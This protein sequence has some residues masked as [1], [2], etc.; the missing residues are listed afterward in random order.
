MRKPRLTKFG[1]LIDKML[2]N[3]E[4]WEIYENSYENSLKYKPLHYVFLCVEDENSFDLTYAPCFTN[5]DKAI[6]YTKALALH[7][8][9]NKKESK[10]VKDPQKKQKQKNRTRY[11][12]MIL[13][14]IM[15]IKP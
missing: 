10:P 8:K 9:M 14:D 7:D 12:R 6:L 11:H 3:E 13:K 1:Q 2:D 5:D 4:N 15:G